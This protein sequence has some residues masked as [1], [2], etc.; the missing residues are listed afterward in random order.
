MTGISLIG[1][2][3]RYVRNINMNRSLHSLILQA[4]EIYSLN[5]TESTY[6]GSYCF[7]VRYNNSHW[8]VFFKQGGAEASV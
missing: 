1:R 6:M 4:S 5:V 7:I 3:R 2:R 8:N